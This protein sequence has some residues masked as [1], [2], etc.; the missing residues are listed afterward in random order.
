MKPYKKRREVERRRESAIALL[1]D[2]RGG[3][4]E[5]VFACPSYE[6]CILHSPLCSPNVC[7]QS[8]T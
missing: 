3:S 6:S 5:Q 4:F 7:L 1:D 8:D 2:V